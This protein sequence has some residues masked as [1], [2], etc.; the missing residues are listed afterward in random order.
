[1]PKTQA[2]TPTH[3]EVLQVHP[4]APL[5]LITAAYWRLAGQTQAR[6]L[7][8]PAAEVELYALTRAYQVLADPASRNAYD[9]ALGIKEQRLAPRVPRRLRGLRKL[10]NGPRIRSRGDAAIDYYE[11]LR[12]HPR[13]D[14]GVIAEAYAAL[15][16][17]YLRLVRLG[18]EPEDL[19]D[20]LEEAYAI[21]SDPDRRRRYDRARERASGRPPEPA[22]D[23]AAPEPAGEETDQQAEI[24]PIETNGNEGVGALAETPAGVSAVEAAGEI[25]R[26]DKSPPELQ[27]TG[28]TA[29]EDEPL[30]AGPEPLAGEAQA[31]AAGLPDSAPPGTAAS[32]TVAEEDE[33]AP[34]ADS[35][36]QKESRLKPFTALA[37]GAAVLFEAMGRQLSQMSRRQKEQLKETLERRKQEQGDLDEAEEMLLQ[38]LAAARGSTQSA[39]GAGRPIARLTL[40]GGPGS[41]ESFEVTSFPVTL[42]SEDGCDI[43]LPGLPEQEARLLYRDGRFVVYR[44]TGAA[45]GDAAGPSTP[46]SILESGD[47]LNLGPY[48]MR[49][50]ALHG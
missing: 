33:P 15:R 16:N 39:D 3:Y 31:P 34:A 28:A 21:T 23:E 48:K 50:T 43:V 42:G 4:A 24:A 5:D 12:V 9:R 30:V 44:L 22:A 20:Y 36:A 45:P 41:G 17:Y 10:V 47:D 46:W 49:L 8:D 26:E 6:R 18:A 32:E 2:T 25:V 27:E 11:I 14:S 13:A 37:G 19:I 38:R 35:R 7:S 40:V 29:V 1:M